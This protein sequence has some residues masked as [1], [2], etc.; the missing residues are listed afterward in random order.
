MLRFEW[1]IIRLS[2]EHTSRRRADGDD[3]SA[4][5]L[6]FVNLAAA[7]A[8]ISYGSDVHR[9]IFDAIDGDRFEGAQPHIERHARAL[10]AYRVEHT[11]SSSGVKCKPAVAR[12][13][14]LRISRNTV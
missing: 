11:R 7:S 4:F 13:R 3:S 5:L 6:G 8:P 12:P 1:S 2:F 10:H 14:I 9:V